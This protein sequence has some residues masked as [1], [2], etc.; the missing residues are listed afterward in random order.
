[1]YHEH[2]NNREVLSKFLK[3]GDWYKPKTRRLLR[4]R[5]LDDGDDI[6]DKHNKIWGDE[7]DWDSDPGEKILV[8]S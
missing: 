4:T 2:K 5:M 1:M 6:E 8:L 7:N 3:R